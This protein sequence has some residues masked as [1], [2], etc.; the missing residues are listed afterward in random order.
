[1]SLLHSHHRQRENK[2]CALEP[3][4]INVN[5]ARLLAGRQLHGNGANMKIKLGMSRWST[6]QF[7]YFN[8]ICEFCECFVVKENCYNVRN[9]DGGGVCCVN[10]HLRYP[11]CGGFRIDC[12]GCKKRGC[13][14]CTTTNGKRLIYA[15]TGCSFCLCKDCNSNFSAHMY[16]HMDI[17]AVADPTEVANKNDKELL[18]M[19]IYCKVRNGVSLN[20]RDLL[21]IMGAD[22]TRALL[23][24]SLPPSFF[25]AD[26]L[27]D[28]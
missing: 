12:A 7:T 17:P 26:E 5:I 11:A 23:V 21:W 3:S 24:E 28:D 18:V 15:C 27:S 2:I 6:L 14:K 16:H 22:S 8:G 1:M 10:C 4:H 20:D 13:S 9:G 25:C 19:C